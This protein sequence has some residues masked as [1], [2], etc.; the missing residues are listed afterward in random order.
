MEHQTL[1]IKNASYA[2]ELKRSGE[3]NSR[4]FSGGYELSR[5]SYEGI[6]PCGRFLF[7]ADGA[8]GAWP[9]VGNGPEELSS[10]RLLGGNDET[11]RVVSEC[12]GVRTTVV[13]TLADSRD[14]A[15]RWE[16]SVENLTDR[17]RG[18]KLVPYL[19][20]MLQ[21]RE[22][23]RN[24][25]QY[26]RLYPEVSYDASLNAVVALH[27]FTK[28]FGYLASSVAP[29]GFLN[30]RIDFIG[31]AGTIWNPRVLQTLD[32]VKP[33]NTDPYP[34]FDPIGSLL[35]GVSV[36]PGSSSQV[37][38]LMGC[39][40]RRED[41]EDQIKRH[42]DPS[43]D[44]SLVHSRQEDRHPMIGHGEIPAGTPQWYTE[45]EEGGATL[46]VLTPFTPR[47]FDH[48]M[49]NARGHVLCVTNRG[50][51]CS[52]SVNAQQNR[53]TTDWADTTTRELPAEAFYIFEEQS[54][55][56]Y[57]PTYEPLR[58]RDAVHDVHFSL[59]GTAKFTMRKGN[60]ETELVTH[61]PVNDPAGVYLLT[62]R[63]NGTVPKK[64]RVAPYFQ[65]VLAHSPEMRGPLTVEKD[66]NTGAVF[67]ENPENASRSG[68]AFVFMTEWADIV[69]TERGAF[70]GDGR[71][72][73]HPQMVESAQAAPSSDSMTCAALLTS[74][75]LPAGG[76]KTIAVIL[77][78]SDTRQEAE[79]C[80][81]KFSTVE[82]ARAA[83]T[84]TRSW[85]LSLKSTLEPETSRPEFEGYVHWMKY[86]ALA[87][88]IW[89]RKGFYQSSGAYGFRDQLQ[90]TVNLIWV[91]PVLA[92]R[93]ILLHTAQQ[94]IEG[95]V[96]HW[97]FVLQEGSTGLVCR[98]HAYDNPLWLAWG[99]SEYLSMTGD[100][101]LLDEQVSYLEAKTPLPPLPEGKHGMGFIPGRSAVKESVYDHVLRV[102]DLVF[103]KRMGANGLPLIGSG[104]WNDGLDEIGC[105]GRGESV[106]LAFFLT[107]IL[108]KFLDHVEAREG[109]ERRA[110]YEDKLRL[111][112]K[113]IE[114][115][116]REDRYLRAIH[117]DGTEIG[118]AGAGYWE[119]DA[120]TA[121]WAVYA[122]VN[123][124]RGR[125]AVDTALRILERDNV[126]SLGY[127]PLREDTKPYLGRSSRYPEGV[128]ENGMYSHGVQWLIKACRILSEQFAEAGD[129]ETA[130]Q[131][132]D[133]CARL[134]FKI[135]AISHVTPDEIEVYGGQPNKQC[136][137]YLTKYDQGRMIWNG[138]T[139]AA[140][141][142]LRQAIE[143]VMGY[144]LDHGVLRTPTDLTEPR[145]ELKVNGLER[146]VSRSPLNR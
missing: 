126:I 3:I 112:Q 97:F 121:A 96:V 136:A 128:R 78:Q 61:V 98:S 8:G 79:A 102:I 67:F 11:L 48:T 75:E 39:A 60:L 84:E 76:E 135:S 108:K 113:S 38:L 25:S 9:V 22:A 129:E 13:I 17:P 49:S 64:L 142:M 7:V 59:D 82:A 50:L 43:V 109:A 6:D 77:G 51:H 45:Y 16:I 74:I 19:E 42:L 80:I 20:W 21:S 27:R 93:Q 66:R 52:A 33:L 40:E 23:D 105:E 111:M 106:W 72:F 99:V 2:V 88:R 56:W 122:D 44:A 90:D 139:G 127:P 46:R 58:D 37:N 94:F 53:L 47:P 63:N 123:R 62:I 87:E 34:T 110:H 31:R 141:W 120:L 101:S 65:I 143:G 36:G 103:E 137:D 54:G 55:Q 117:D 15:E 115:V 68:P 57:S 28:H 41:V 69:A 145:G 71:S 5:P 29:E 118:V 83:L 107:Y 35:L 133:A 70:F 91:D 125:T 146:D 100:L 131:Y 89:A 32:F 144:S 95:D 124:A 30:G 10:K 104:D 14:C 114:N 86:Q 92:R 12:N 1:Q 132:R 26:N 81:G 138:Y 119:I 140:A 134:W 18:L 24:H 73:A 4:A 130:Q 116:W 85:W